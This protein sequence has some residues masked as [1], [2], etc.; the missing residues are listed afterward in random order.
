[1]VF[2]NGIVQ[3]ITH[4]ANHNIKSTEGARQQE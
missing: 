1:V 4:F 2:I 3:D